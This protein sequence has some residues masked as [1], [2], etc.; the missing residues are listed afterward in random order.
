MRILKGIKLDRESRLIRLLS[1][2]PIK[3][4]KFFE[5]EVEIRDGLKD[6]IEVVH[7]RA[8]AVLSD[9]TASP[10]SFD[11]DSCPLDLGAKTYARS[12]DEIYEKI[13]FHGDQLRGILDILHCTA[14][15][16]AARIASAP[17]P[18]EWITDPLR[19]RW[20]GDPLVLDAAFQMAIVW[21]FENRG[22]VSL[23]S[24]SAS[25]RQFA[26]TFPSGG[27]LALLD[28]TEV[29]DHKMTGD[30]TFLDS[31]NNVVATLSGCESIMDDSLL[32]AF[33]A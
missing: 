24:Y 27:V 5:V 4:G 17:S 25:Y 21:C 19:S 32:Q 31:G 28:V 30:Y 6:N 13:L 22:K 3:K 12:M 16:M 29:T 10:P 20:I 1:G 14:T 15:G 7:S 9:T 11:I 8:R 18:A 2:K 26:K 33:K 23:P